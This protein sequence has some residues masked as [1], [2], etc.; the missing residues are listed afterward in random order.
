[1]TGACMRFFHSLLTPLLVTTALF[2]SGS[3]PSNKL[4]AADITVIYPGFEPEIGGKEVDWIYGDFLFRNDLITAVIAAP[5][6]T[7][8]A[9]LT[10]RSVGASLIDITLNNPSNDQLSVFSPAGGRY[11]FQNPGTIEM[12]K[13]DKGA[14]WRCRSSASVAKDSS[15]A[16]VEYRLQ[17]GKP[18]IEVTV[19]ISG[20]DNTAFVAYDGIR[21]DRTFQFDTKDNLAYCTDPFFRQTIGFLNPAGASGATW[22]KER[23]ALLKY[24]DDAVTKDT[25]TIAWTTRIYPAT[26]LLDLQGGIAGGTPRSIQVTAPGRPTKPSESVLRPTLQITSKSNPDLSGSVAT[27]DS[28]LA[29]LRLPEGDYTVE[30]KTVGYPDTTSLLSFDA[31]TTTQSISLQAPSGFSAIVRDAEERT[32]PVKATIYALEGNAPDFG[33]DSTRTF[34]KNCVYAVHGTFYCPLPPGKYEVYFTRGPEYDA[35]VRQLEIKDGQFEALQISLPRVV[36][37]TGWVSTELHSH[38]SPSGDNVSDQYGRVENLL[39]EH[40]EFAPCTEHARISSYTPHLEAMQLQ[41]LM[42]TISGMELTG[43]PLPLNHQNAFP[44][45][46]HPHTQNGGGPSTDPNPVKQIERLAL[47]D[48]ASEKVVQQNHPNIHQMFG[49]VDTDGNPDEGFREMFQWMDVIE[50]HPLQTIF[51]DVAA[52]PPSPRDFRNPIF[53]WMQLLNQGIR[54]PGVVNTD[55]HYNHHGSGWLRNWFASSTDDPAKIQIDEMIHS[56]EHGHII[57]ST[58]PFLEVTASSNERDAIAI[59]GDDFVPGPSRKVN[60]HVKAQ[61]PNWLEIN[62]VQLFLNGKPIDSLNRTRRTH[63]DQFGGP[64]DVVKFDQTFELTLTEDTHIIVAVIGEGLDMTKIYGESYGKIPPVAV[65]NPIFIDIAGDGFK[66]NL[67]ELGVP[68]PRKKS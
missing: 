27:D 42:A 28:G 49:D 54:V 41:H 16:S 29:L 31:Q 66:P 37:T 9:N 48:N 34:V 17:D 38:S 47:W 3:L 19:R 22:T 64:K 33:P 67:D 21:A 57:M 5:L 4:G 26:S 13:D 11:L 51:D 24:A 61:C 68:L 43:S 8:D 1:M 18:Y 14:F 7:R 32:I 15:T 52:N 53:G 35:A 50:V 25:N 6:P 30:A 40:L 62:R 45:H 46:Q 12:G 56:A 20:L 44:L 10:V 55:A 60:L 23:L 39:C 58:G 2:G 63:S 65:S 59:P 36:D